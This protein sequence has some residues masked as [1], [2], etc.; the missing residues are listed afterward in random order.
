MRL[1]FLSLALAIS[2][3][4]AYSGGSL[5]VADFEDA[6]P[7][8][9]VK[10]NAD[11]KVTGVTLGKTMNALDGSAALEFHANL[12]GLGA[13]WAACTIP[14][15]GAL[16]AGADTVEFDARG[17]DNTHD[18]FFGVKEKD[19]SSWN[20]NVKLTPEWKHYKLPLYQFTW[21]SGPSRRE[22]TAP[23]FHE[24]ESVGPWVGNKFQGANG[25]AIDN[26]RIIDAVPPIA[27]RLTSTPK[28]PLQK[29]VKLALEASETTGGPRSAFTG[30]LFL[31]MVDRNAANFPLQVSMQD[32]HAEFEF[33]ARQTG[34][35]NL[36]LFERANRYE[37]VIP[38]EVYQ[39]G[40]KVTYGFEG[41]EDQQIVFANAKLT[42]KLTLEGEQRT[43]PLS[44]HVEI[45][46]HK[47]RVV[48][49]KSSSVSDLQSG[50]SSLQV[51]CAGLFDVD[52]KV[53]AEPI[54]KLPHVSGNQPRYLGQDEAALAQAASEEVPD[55][56]TTDVVMGSFV[57]LESLPEQATV[58]G[59]D[60][61]KLWVL[62]VSP[63]ENLLYGSPF[64][65]CSGGLFHMKPDKIRREGDKRLR[66][67]RKLGSFWGRNDLW[68][69]EIETTAGVFS[70]PKPDLVVEEYNKNKLRLLGILCYASAWSKGKPPE[71]MQSREEWRRWV[72][73]M[74]KRYGGKV[75]AYE[76]WNEPNHGF[77]GP[78]A[79]PA[80][81][82]ELVKTTWE[83]LRKSSGGSHE[84]SAPR[85]V[86]GA[87]AGFDPVFLDE[88]MQ[89]EYS[90]YFDAVS[91]HP[92][93]ERGW[94]NPED[95]SF[96]DLCEDFRSIMR[97][98]GVVS[99]ERWITEM[100]WSTL[101]DQGVSE[102]DQANYL[103]RMYTI[104][105]ARGIHK[106]FWFNLCD[107]TPIAWHA[108]SDS[109]LGLYDA[110]Y[111]PKPSALA[112]NIMGFMMAQMEPRFETR[113]GKA[114][115][116][117]FQILQQR[118]K[119]PGMMHVAWCPGKGEEEDIELEMTG[120]AGVYALDYLGAERPP[121]LLKS[122]E[123]SGKRAA[124]GSDDSVTTRT[125]RFHLTDEPLYIWDVGAEPK[126][127]PA[128]KTK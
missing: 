83:E 51:P 4:A 86:A 44:A 1:F 35:L 47:G 30:E 12:S 119:W 49:A 20:G 79:G 46:D 72:S 3:A 17:I 34:Q 90:Q 74:F 122:A 78:N 25:F 29:S 116:Y 68:W 109:H 85:L 21:F 59:E 10:H 50:R 75:T 61:F 120:G 96:A 95:N 125:Y 58:L 48:A 88:I 45:R 89:G 56:V 62:A 66:L 101:P 24:L 28:V 128:K 14:I 23:K 91:M 99:K 11:K 103:V 53:V 54:A 57:R 107:W 115:I 26:I 118:Y 112:Y 76:V 63:P 15:K 102:M 104:A 19:N 9:S 127:R 55:G 111:R 6:D 37:L 123:P 8:S 40:M 105:L 92:Y 5:K 100:G 67:H 22:K 121:V 106:I 71:D 110:S 16:P 82:R 81:Y 98:H 2:S 94:E 36:C 32:G 108:Q 7:A 31:D 113:R 43:K 97:K 27:L 69:N 93:P 33:F 114:T 60:K 42:P 124:P 13:G 18:M 77:W 39:D 70:W 64:A 117:S 65:V 126:S 80:V 38:I 87:T 52:V 41:Y 84:K 73:N